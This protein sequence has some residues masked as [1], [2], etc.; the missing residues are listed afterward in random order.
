MAAAR[1]LKNKGFLLLH[2]LVA[3]ALLG[4]ACAML[5]PAANAYRSGMYAMQAECA[6]QQLATDI[7]GLQQFCFYNNSTKNR[8][9][10]DADRG[11][12][13]VYHVGTAVAQR[14]FSSESGL[15]FSQRLNALT[16]SYEGAP[17]ATMN[18][19][20]KCRH[21]SGIS[22]WLQVQPVTGRVVFK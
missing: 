14:R 17:S 2:L 20:I 21:A 12:Y 16:F 6:A 5:L 3:C 8:L 15:Y 11:G 1:R 4:T 10:I 22:K 18:Y 7:A 9:E 19:I 13:K